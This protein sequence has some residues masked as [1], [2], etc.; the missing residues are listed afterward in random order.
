[1]NKFT[2]QDEQRYIGHTM[3]MIKM[4][5]WW[6]HAVGIWT[7]WVAV[8]GLMS[9]SVLGIMF[10]FIMFFLIKSASDALT[11]HRTDLV[12]LSSM[13]EQMEDGLYLKEALTKLDPVARA[14]IKKYYINSAF[15][16]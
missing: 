14:H 8:Y 11:N 3:S 1:M 10:G 5:M 6:Q 9:E 12:R 15:L 13:L 4:K 16:D 7:A 2:P